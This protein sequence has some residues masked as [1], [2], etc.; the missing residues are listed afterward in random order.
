MGTWQLRNPLLSQAVVRVA[1]ALTGVVQPPQGE[2]VM[3]ASGS[4]DHRRRRTCVPLQYRYFSRPSVSVSSILGTRIGSPGLKS[5]LSSC[6][7]F[8]NTVTGT[9]WLGRGKWLCF[10]FAFFDRRAQ[11][12]K[13]L[14]LLSASCLHP[15][16]AGSI[17]GSYFCFWK[18]PTS[19]GEEVFLRNL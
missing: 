17:N 4:H 13:K 15:Q 7:N 5:D 1:A 14:C 8:W 18:P 3:E 9:P 12:S 19:W 10:R 16:L 11:P 6:Q 2:V